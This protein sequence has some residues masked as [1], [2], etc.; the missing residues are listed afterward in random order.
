MNR[1][2]SSIPRVLGRCAD[3]LTEAREAGRTFTRL[4]PLEA[5][6]PMPGGIEMVCQQPPKDKDCPLVHLGCTHV[7]ERLL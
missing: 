6:Q 2:Q 5:E 3:V 4:H 1:W 7:Q